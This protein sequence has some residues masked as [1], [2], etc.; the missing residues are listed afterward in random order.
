[1]GKAIDPVGLTKEEEEKLDIATNQVLL[2]VETS[3][4]SDEQTLMVLTMAINDWTTRCINKYP[5]RKGALL[6]AIENAM[7]YILDKLGDYEPGEKQ[8]G[9]ERK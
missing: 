9:R 4:L 8:E 6:D 2:F 3:G 7:D 5:E 1:M